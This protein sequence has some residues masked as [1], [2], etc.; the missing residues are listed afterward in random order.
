MPVN[1]R[2]IGTELEHGSLFP[3][4]KTRLSCMENSVISLFT[5]VCIRALILK[6]ELASLRTNRKLVFFQPGD[7]VDTDMIIRDGDGNSA[8]IPIRALGK[9]ARKNW[10]RP[11]HVP[12]FSDRR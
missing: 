3:A 12:D 11:H 5:E 9:E 8:F 2:I 6:Q 1:D 4:V 7:L 10:P